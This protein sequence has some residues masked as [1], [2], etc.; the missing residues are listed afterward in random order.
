M[1]WFLSRSMKKKLLFGCYS[2]VGLF[3]ITALILQQI[4]GGSLITGLIVI[5][6]LIAVSY[7]LIH[8][9]ERSLSGPIEHISSVALSIS[10]GDFTNRVPVSSNDALGQLGHSFNSMIDKLKDILHDTNVISRHV[11]DTSRDIYY[12]NNNMK[13]VM[14][15]VASSSYDLATGATEISVDVSAVSESV[16]EI[17][18]KI[19]SY[20]ASTRAMNHRSEQTIQLVS[21]GRHAVDRQSQGMERNIEATANVAATIEELAKQAAGITKMTRTISEIAEQ[22]N[23]L[24]L[25][26]SIEAARAGE[27]GKGFAVVAQEVRKL[28]EESS[29]SAKEVFTLVRGI[30]TGI[31]QAIANIQKNGEIVQ[32][33][34]QLIRETERVFT[35]IV[36]GVK[37]ITDEIYNFA[38]ESDMMLEGAH[39]ISNAMVNI[40]SITQQSAAGTEQVSA[41]MNEQIHSVVA[42]VEQ[43]EKMQQAVIQMQRALSVFKF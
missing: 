7:P 15:Q 17:E 39:T 14:E 24:S 22:T 31:Q 10:K 43:T 40:S 18:S 25:N 37:F 3:S 1:N 34:T 4:A 35:E 21:K 13:L 5:I 2:L 6:I 36:D 19:T 12:K 38:K 42:M 30:E 32:T 33:Q 41:S 8:F 27:H 11:A 29:A 28:A 26:A 16:R 9:L 23:L 20:A